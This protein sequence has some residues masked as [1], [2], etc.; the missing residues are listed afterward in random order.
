MTEPT[1]ASR[2]DDH[3][4]L[5]AAQQQGIRTSRAGFDDVAVRHHA[6]SGIAP[7]QV[8]LGVE[9]GPWQFEAPFY[10]NGMTGGTDQAR[11]LNRTLAQA[12]A[13]AHVP[14]ASGSVGIALDDPSTAD[15][16]TVIRDE[17]P[18]GIVLANIGAGRSVDDARRAVELL[19]ADGLQ[20][21]VNA[22]QETVMPEGSRDFSGWLE[23]I[24]QIAAALDADGVPLLVKEVGF[25]LSSRTLRQLRDAG[26]SLVDVAGT[27]GTDFARIENDRRDPVEDV[28]YLSAAAG[29]GLSTPAALLDAATLEPQVRADLTVLAS[30]GVRHPLDVVRCLAL[31]AR[32]VGVAG[33]FLSVAL[34]HPDDDGAALASV[35][36]AWAEQLR[37]LH[38]LFGAR[39]PEELTGTDVVVTGTTAEIA[40]RCGADLDQLARRTQHRTGQTHSKEQM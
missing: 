31:G 1:A 29:F 35:M 5:A 28:S 20:L 17:N 19:K 25:G 6:L 3:L 33:S 32:A 9:V 12:A 18:H 10:V 26:V 21:H 23:L 13:R 11:A 16:F 8:S 15:S 38:A 22:V 24:E 27:G 4:R 2:K 30:G 39:T 14:M 36:T 40:Q 34:A 7:E 37:L